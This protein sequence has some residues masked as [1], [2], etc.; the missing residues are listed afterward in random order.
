MNLSRAEIPWPAAANRYEY[1]RRIW[2][3]FPVEESESRRDGANDRT[4][5][6]FRVEE[7]RPGLPARVL[8]QSTKPPSP[9]HGV[10]LIATRTLDPRPTAGQRLAFIVTAN[11]IKN[12]KDQQV[13]Q[14]PGKR[15]ATCRVPLIREDDQR[16]WLARKL[17]GAAEVE[18]V[19]VLPHQPVFFR[20][21]NRGGKLVTIT[22]EGV[23]A[24]Q[25]PQ[26]LVRHLAN[27]IGPAKAF[28]CG[29]MMVRRIGSM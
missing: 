18:A 17:D 29:L 1:H 15:R 12:I 3:L 5:F 21:G 2:R 28:G 23:L 19:S 4:G 8:V 14:K 11:P 25:D 26:A 24:V 16:A 20:R 10:N 27:G 9:A 7:S 22:Y 13:A 6:L